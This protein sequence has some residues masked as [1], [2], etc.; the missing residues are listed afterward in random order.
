MLSD[1]SSGN[2]LA[3]KKGLTRIIQNFRETLFCCIATIQKPRFFD[4]ENCI[5]LL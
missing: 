5:E 4:E 1:C 3:K 2:E